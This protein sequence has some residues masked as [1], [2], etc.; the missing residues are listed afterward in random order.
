MICFFKKKNPNIKVPIQ[1][2]QLP[3]IGSDKLPSFPSSLASSSLTTSLIHTPRLSS[4]EYNTSWSTQNEHVPYVT[5][6][7]RAVLEK[8]EEL[9]KRYDDMSLAM[10]TMQSQLDRL[11]ARED[12]H[13]K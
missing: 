7:N 3:Y 6:D 11:S 9:T 13:S 12:A 10:V 8:L 4:S 2:N 5:L 1:G